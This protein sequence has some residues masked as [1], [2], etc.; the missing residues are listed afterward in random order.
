VAGCDLAFGHSGQTCVAGVVVWDSH[1]CEIA[2]RV[3]AVRTVRFPYVPG[4]LTFREAPALLAA[5]RKLACEPDVFIFDG[6]GISH[7]RRFGLAAHMGLL[8]DRPSIGC[9]KSRLIGRHDEPKRAFGAS[10]P[11]LDGDELVGRVLRTRADAKP[12]YVSIGHKIALAA[13]CRVVLT[14]CTGFRVPE[15]TRLAD[16]WVGQ[17]ARAA[18]RPSD[19]NEPRIH[20]D[21]HELAANDVGRGTGISP[22]TR[23]TAFQAVER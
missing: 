7:P 14:C 20:T 13:A 22:V 9:A 15:P 3:S 16:I 21:K 1:R 18:E 23:P 4:L 12:V 17:L 5:I 11:L 8:L 19:E 2:E 6:Q 10:T